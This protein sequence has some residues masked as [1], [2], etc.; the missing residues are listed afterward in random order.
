MS[1]RPFLRPLKEAV[2]LCGIRRCVVEVHGCRVDG[3]VVGF[4]LRAT[5][6]DGS[7]EAKNEEQGVLPVVLPF[8][9][10][11]LCAEQDEAVVRAAQVAVPGQPGRGSSNSHR[12]QGMSIWLNAF[13]RS[14]VRR[15]RSS[16]WSWQR[17][18]RRMECRSLPKYCKRLLTWLGPITHKGF[19]SAHYGA[20][21]LASRASFLQCT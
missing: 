1:S 8:S 20:R 16:S 2:W 19:L 14:T 12:K 4:S 7:V 15:Q 18:H 5:L 21:L 13:S 6:R 17:G 11:F 9:W 10:D 3:A